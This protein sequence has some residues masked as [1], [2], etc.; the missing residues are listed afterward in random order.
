MTP[1][2]VTLPPRFVN[3]HPGLD[4]SRDNRAW[5]AP[6]EGMLFFRILHSVDFI[7]PP[8]EWQRHVSLSI[9]LSDWGR[10]VRSCTVRERR[11]FE[12]W[13]AETFPG[14]VFEAQYSDNP[15][16]RTFHL[17]QIPREYPGSESESAQ[18]RA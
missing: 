6:N 9:G 1:T 15:G 8:G 12:A 11:E 10:P 3:T 4:R 16:P 7:D 13:V 2:P 17:W 14:E 18:N 5:L